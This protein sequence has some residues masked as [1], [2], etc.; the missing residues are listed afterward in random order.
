MGCGRGAAPPK[1]MGSAVYGPSGCTCG[2][3]SRNVD[4][5]PIYIRMSDCG[6][7][8]RK[9]AFKPFDG[10]TKYVGQP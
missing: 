9:W 7:H 3:P 8:I 2:S 6:R 1:C 10:C 4:C 5:P